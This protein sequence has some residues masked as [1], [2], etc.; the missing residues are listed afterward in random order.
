MDPSIWVGIAVIAAVVALTGFAISIRR[1]A[2]QP[3]GSMPRR[4]EAN[5]DLDEERAKGLYGSGWVP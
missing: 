2:E 3:R 4:G 5:L 1:R